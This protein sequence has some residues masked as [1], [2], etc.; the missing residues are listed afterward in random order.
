MEER[1]TAR[2]MS[3]MWTTNLDPSMV[4]CHT[5]PCR[6]IGHSMCYGCV[7]VIADEAIWEGLLPDR[8]RGMRSRLAGKMDHCG[9][10]SQ[11]VVEC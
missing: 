10:R 6:V 8:R 2:S 7:V 11:S 1:A 4:D 3:I 9:R 5:P